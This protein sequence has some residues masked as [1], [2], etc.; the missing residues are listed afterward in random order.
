M[1]VQLATQPAQR[2]VLTSQG[3]ITHQDVDMPERRNRCCHDLLGN[4]RL[5]E[6]P[7]CVGAR[8]VL[9]REVCPHTSTDT[10]EV[11]GSP[12]LP[13]I[14][15]HEV[16]RKH[17]R[18]VR[19]E[20]TR[21]RITHAGTATDPGDQRDPAAQRQHF[22]FHSCPQCLVHT[23]TL[24]QPDREGNATTTTD[25]TTGTAP[26]RSGT[27]FANQRTNSPAPNGLPN[28]HPRGRANVLIMAVCSGTG[29]F[30]NSHR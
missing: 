22:P 18:A 7:V 21:D 2:P 30:P 16:V 13:A 12:L 10:V 27:V 6:I 26:L 17:A 20:T 29:P 11:V 15:R 24:A 25:T 4:V 3:V 9:A 5:G 14:M 19:G 8:C 28:T 1:P 23:R